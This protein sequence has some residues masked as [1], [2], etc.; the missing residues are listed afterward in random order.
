MVVKEMAYQTSKR[1][2]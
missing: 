1:M 2:G